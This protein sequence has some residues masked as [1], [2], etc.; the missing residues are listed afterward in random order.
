MYHLN[1]KDSPELQSKKE[2]S[3]QDVDPVCVFQLGVSQA[4]PLWLESP[5]HSHADLRT[6]LQ[7]KATAKSGEALNV[8]LRYAALASCTAILTEP[9][10]D[11]FAV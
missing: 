8:K 6:C 7:G 10:M 2:Q 5:F 1:H 9:K 11:H 4:L 3:L